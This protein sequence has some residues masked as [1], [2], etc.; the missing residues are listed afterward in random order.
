M[1]E[2]RAKRG[3]MNRSNSVCLY[4]IILLF[5]CSGMVVELWRDQHKS[6]NRPPSTC[7]MLLTCLTDQMNHEPHYDLSIYTVIILYCPIWVLWIILATLLAYGE[8]ILYTTNARRSVTLLPQ[9]QLTSPALPEAPLLSP[10]L[11]CSFGYLLQLYTMADRY[12]FSLTTFSPRY[13]VYLLTPNS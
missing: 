4:C 1:R 13:D 2:K 6:V 7:S 11:V 10:S 12:S 8:C 9:L 3:R 5:Y